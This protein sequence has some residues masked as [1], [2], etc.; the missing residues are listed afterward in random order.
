MVVGT[1]VALLISSLGGIVI[2]LIA[3]R[4]LKAVESAS[5]KAVEVGTGT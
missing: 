4:P 1:V 2:Y 5:V 3:R